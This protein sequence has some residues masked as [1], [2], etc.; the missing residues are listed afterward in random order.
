[1]TA[2][3]RDDRASDARRESG[4]LWAA[5]LVLA[6]LAGSVWGAWRLGVMVGE[7]VSWRQSLPAVP[8]ALRKTPMPKPPTMPMQRRPTV[9]QTARG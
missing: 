6:M 3:A 9:E 4:G 2:V 5:V 7:G 8:E 1:M